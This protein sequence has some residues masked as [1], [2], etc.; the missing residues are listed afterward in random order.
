MSTKSRS[1][2]DTEEDEDGASGESEMI[3]V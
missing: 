1:E 2:S 3:N